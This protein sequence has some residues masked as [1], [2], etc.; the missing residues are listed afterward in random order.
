M[1]CFFIV[2]ALLFEEVGYVFCAEV[3]YSYATCGSKNTFNDWFGSGATDSLRAR[4]T[5]KH[6]KTDK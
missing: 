4:K 5:C 3:Y 1:F 6:K 2:V